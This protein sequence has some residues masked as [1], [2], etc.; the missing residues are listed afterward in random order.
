[1]GAP[2]N[3]NENAR[4]PMNRMVKVHKR[5]KGGKNKGNNKKKTGQRLK[6]QTK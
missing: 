3:K 1:M 6:L 4:M 5:S 2:R